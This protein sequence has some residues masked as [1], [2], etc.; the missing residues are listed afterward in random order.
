MSEK[1]FCYFID[2]H[3]D[4]RDPSNNRTTVS[5][6]PDRMEPDAVLFTD[7]EHTDYGNVA[8]LVAIFTRTLAY[9]LQHEPDRATVIKFLRDPK[10]SRTVI[11]QKHLEDFF[12][13]R[14]EQARLPFNGTYD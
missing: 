11:T 10:T 14:E 5:Y 4:A 7:R 8:D 1:K 9:F 12:G 6:T 3:R 2:W 13:E